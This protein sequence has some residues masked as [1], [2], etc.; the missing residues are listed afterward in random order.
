[1]CQDVP[2]GF[3]FNTCQMASSSIRGLC[4]FAGRRRLLKKYHTHEDLPAR[5]WLAKWGALR[6][7]LLP[8]ALRYSTDT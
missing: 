7:R 4:C 8:L 2:D 3:L 1:M 6:T 5:A